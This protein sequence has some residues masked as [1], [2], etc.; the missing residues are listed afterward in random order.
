MVERSE[1]GR[2]FVV[3]TYVRRCHERK[4]DALDLSSFRRTIIDTYSVPDRFVSSIVKS[5][6]SGGKIGSRT[7]LPHTSSEGS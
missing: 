6:F 3:Q 7:D 2:N 4:I 1:D 5:E